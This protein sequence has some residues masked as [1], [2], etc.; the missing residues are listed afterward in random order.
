MSYLKVAA[1][2]PSTPLPHSTPLH[3]YYSAGGPCSREME[4]EINGMRCKASR[5]EFF[6]PCCIKLTQNG[7]GVKTSSNVNFVC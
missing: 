6:P 1:L 5:E 2:P 4:N 3:V 7:V